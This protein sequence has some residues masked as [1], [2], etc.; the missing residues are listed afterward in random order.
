MLV[1]GNK[2]LHKSIHCFSLPPIITCPNC[3]ECK[4]W[5]YALEIY[6][7]KRFNNAKIRWDRNYA[8]TDNSPTFIAKMVDEIEKKK[9]KII[10]IHVGGDFYSQQYLD[11]WT[12]IAEWFHDIKFFGFSKCFDI[13]DFRWLNYLPNVNIINSILPDGTLNFGRIGEVLHKQDKY[14]YPICR[15]S[16]HHPNI[17]CGLNCFECLTSE[18][19]LFV[20]HR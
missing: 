14:G 3:S 5:C 8:L 7:S 10:R 4:K 9:P 2:K 11:S 17:K 18:R 12:A 15:Y 6:N 20:L 13:F 16:A 19:M 1:P